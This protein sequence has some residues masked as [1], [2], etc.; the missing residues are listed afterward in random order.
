MIVNCPAEYWKVANRPKGSVTLVILSTSPGCLVG[1]RGHQPK[2][3]GKGRDTK[4]RIITD[5]DGVAC[6]VDHLRHKD[7]SRIRGRPV[8]LREDLF[9]TVGEP[10]LISRRPGLDKGGVTLGMRQKG[11]GT[12][13]EGV[14][15]RAPIWN[16][17]RNLRQLH[18]GI[19]AHVGE[20]IEGPLRSQVAIG[21]GKQAVE[22]PFDCK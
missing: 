5:R 4:A 20:P 17:D 18:R 2:S 13:I 3:I 12:L 1:K 10:A 15:F 19:V 9:G 16:V 6:R 8:A 22:Y 14:N 21:E 7:P 11:L